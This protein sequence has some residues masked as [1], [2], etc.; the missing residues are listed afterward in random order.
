MKLWSWL[1]FAIAFFMIAI[2]LYGAIYLDNITETVNTRKSIFPILIY[3]NSEQTVEELAGYV[4]Q[5]PVCDSYQIIPPD[6]LE[7]I[8]IEKYQLTDYK[9]IAGD[10]RLPFQVE[11]TV[12]PL[13]MKQLARFVADLSTTFSQN[14]VHYNA[15]LWE[16]VDTQ[17][18]K[19]RFYFYILKLVFLCLYIGVLYAVR[20][21][22]IQKHQNT[23]SAILASGTPLRKLAKRE[24]L[25]NLFFW[26]VSTGCAVVFDFV[27]RYFQLDK[28]LMGGVYELISFSDVRE[29]MSLF[30]DIDLLVMLAVANLV[31]VTVRR[32]VFRVS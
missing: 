5:N 15:K 21:S 23:I 32:A 30:F 18:N 3:T 10:Y 1:S 25:S 11:I 22:F 13:S 24:F 4:Q 19:L 8:L 14:V 20:L 6:S 17:V 7:T 31:L 2:F 9:E 27:I 26:V 12:V 29:F 16:D 28:Y